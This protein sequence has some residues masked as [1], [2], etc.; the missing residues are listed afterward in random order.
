MKRASRGSERGQAAVET[1]ITMP[2]ALFVVLGTLQLFL[3]L[4]GRIIAEYAAF[5]AARAGSVNVGDC[6]SMTHAA[7]AAVLPA[8]TR[9]DGAGRVIAGFRLREGNRYSQFLDG[10]SGAI[11]WI[12]RQLDREIRRDHKDSFDDRY[13][14]ESRAELMVDMVFWF[15]MKIP[16]ANWIIARSYLASVGILPY[17]AMNPLSPAQ[18]RARWEEQ[19]RSPA[20]NRVLGE[21]RNRVL[22][23]EYDFPIRTAYRLRMM[24]P[25]VEIG[26]ACPNSPGSL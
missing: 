16:F 20:T 9:T 6:R 11:V 25:A 23:R 15:P 24:T 7:I 8:V 14:P 10:R 18:R 26:R 5:R 21:M 17:F 2:L 4:N 12:Q 1:A 13:E 3:M 19:G 22:R